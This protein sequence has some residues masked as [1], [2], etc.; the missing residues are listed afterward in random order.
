MS[1]LIWDKDQKK[2]M[3]KQDK[4]VAK[5]EKVPDSRS[6]EVDSD[7]SGDEEDYKYTNEELDKD[8]DEMVKN[9]HKKQKLITDTDSE[10]SEL[11]KPR[12][13]LGDKISLIL[14]EIKQVKMALSLLTEHNNKVKDMVKG[15]LKDIKY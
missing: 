6:L 4:L 2:Y 15:V 5:V 12:I 3:I 10:L 13:P 1:K 8:L 11:M 7:L 14:T 9:P